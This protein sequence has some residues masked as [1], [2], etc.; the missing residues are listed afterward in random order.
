MSSNDSTPPRPVTFDQLR[1]AV[2]PSFAMLAGMQ[3]DLFTPLTDGPKNADE[4]AEALGVNA[5]KLAP[6]LYLL[7]TTGLLTASDGRFSNTSESDQ[8]FVRGGPTYIGGVHELFAELWE[9]ALKTAES[10]R[11]GV[12]QAKHDFAAMSQEELGGFFRGLH[13][14][15]Q[16]AGRQLAQILD[17]GRHRHLL[18][19]GGG[20]GGLAI[21]ACKAC[22]ELHATV[23]ELP[24]IVPITKEFLAEAGMTD[25]VQVAS[26]DVIERP[27]EG[28]FDVAILRFLI[29]VLS[30]DQ[31]F[32]AVLNVSQAIGLGGMIHIVGHVL[33]DDR[34]SPPAATC[35]NLVFLN[36]YDNGQAYTEAEH[37]EWLQK[38]G[39]ADI[40]R[41]V[42]PDGSTL[43]T[44]RKEGSLT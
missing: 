39:F 41:S 8:Y 37:R 31:A 16:A 30:A 40:R 24:S 20:S 13:P 38:A 1:H 35:L 12:P 44:A 9:A 11:T 10:I 2:Y 15:A 21:A 6:L 5:N 3:L 42:L 18:D 33:D 34:L 25:R 27:P 29:Q 32:R 19:V 43:V 26:V 23:V 7:V 17:L 28:T 4:L 22:P 14:G 36:L